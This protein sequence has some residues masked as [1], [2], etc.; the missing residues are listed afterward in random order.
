MREYSG[1]RIIELTGGPVTYT[2]G[3]KI[4]WWK[5]EEP[6]GYKKTA[7]YVLPHAY[8]VGKL[9]GLSGICSFL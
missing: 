5:N 2:H 4:L 7:K 1:E 8:V 3:P 6:E 9:C